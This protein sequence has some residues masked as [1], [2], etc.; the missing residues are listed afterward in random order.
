MKKF[1]L[2]FANVTSNDLCLYLKNKGYSDEE[3]VEAGLAINSEKRGMSDK[4]WNR[5]MF[6]IQDL[7]NKVIG[8][9]GRVLGDGDPNILTPRIR[10]YL[11]RAGIST[12]LTTQG[13][14]RKST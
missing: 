1:G 6:P 8:F 11:I 13:V 5:V 9:G 3:I 14:Q 4:F 7:S 12:A 2:G 10:R